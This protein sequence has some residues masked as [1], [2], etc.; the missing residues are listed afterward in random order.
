MKDGFIKVAAATNEV[1]VADVSTNLEKIKAIIA[2][3]ARE[4]SKI[5]VFPELC[6]CGYSCRDIFFQE[7][8]LEACE[9][10]LE[11]LIKYSSAYDMLIAVGLPYEHFG[12]LYNVAAVICGGKLLGLV[13]KKHL[14]NYQEF[15]EARQFTKGFDEP[16][17]I[18]FAG[19]KTYFGAKQIFTCDTVKHL[20]VGVELCEDLWTPNPP[21]TALAMAG[22]TVILNLSASDELTGKNA[23][24]RQLVLDQSARLYCGYIYAS[25]SDSES[26]TDVV[27]SGHNIIAE[28]G[29]LLAESK[30]FSHEVI[31]SEIDVVAIYQKRMRMSTYDINCEGYHFSSFSLK[32]VD[33]VITRYIDA[34]P[35]VPSDVAKRNKRCEEILDIQCRGLK[36]R[37]AHT[38]TKAA[39][40]GISG[41]LDSTLALL[42]TVRAFDMLGLDRKGIIG[43]TMPGF[44][45]TDRTYDNAVSMIKKLGVTF[46]EISIVDAV[47]GHFKDIEQSMDLIKQTLDTMTEEGAI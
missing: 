5:L 28:S 12:K 15:Y 16:V 25:A 20:K 1:F 45:T 43:V 29:S 35:F 34:H 7:S 10:A 39:V 11:D 23:Y 30:L 32:P 14:P 42:V 26:T 3:A 38:N 31:Y 17:E 37:L 13:P 18:L 6:L 41:G 8:L 44:G 9:K 27:Y 46:K 24:R 40:I 19:E 2:D 21:S 33:T 47:T 36:K 4:G 22:A